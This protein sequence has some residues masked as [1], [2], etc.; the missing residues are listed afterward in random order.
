MVD[1]ADHGPQ[2]FA[3]AVVDTDRKPS[4][5]LPAWHNQDLFRSRQSLFLFIL[6]QFWLHCWFRFVSFDIHSSTT[7]PDA[8]HRKLL[9]TSFFHFLAEVNWRTALLWTTTKVDGWWWISVGYCQGRSALDPVSG[10]CW[11]SLPPSKKWVKI[12]FCHAY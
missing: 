11:I 6:I 2:R 10:D 7:E 8:F 12:L 5:L 4:S 3:I 9:M 1:A